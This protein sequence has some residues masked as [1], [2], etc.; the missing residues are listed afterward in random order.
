MA[1]LLLQPYMYHASVHQCN[2]TVGC[3]LI[4]SPHTQVFYYS[5]MY[6]YTST[7]LDICHVHGLHALTGIVH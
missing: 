6:Y 5:C 3:L 7:C 4:N 2:H 1:P